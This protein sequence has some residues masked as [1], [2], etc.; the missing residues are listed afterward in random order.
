MTTTSEAS[1]LRGLLASRP[2]LGLR[3]H[4]WLICVALFMY[5][6]DLLTKELALMWLKPLESH[7]LLGPWLQIRLLFNS[8]AA[9]SLGE[10]FTV[11]FAALGCVALLFILFL[12]APRV[13]GRLENVVV[14][15]LI[16]GI[17]GNLTDR[18]LRPNHATGE[19]IP[20]HGS[21]I[22]WLG[23]QYFAVFNV[24]DMCITAAAV[25]I[26]LGLLRTSVHRGQP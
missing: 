8:G 23:I 21:V 14:G 12:V 1:S 20:F 10:S 5:G 22:D 24:A 25:T 4:W 19:T 6:V 16:A 2:V 11:V 9:F 3:H 18:M 13:A 17:A 15:L 7:Y 26:I